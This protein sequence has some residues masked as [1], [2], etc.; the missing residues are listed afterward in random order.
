[1][2]ASGVAAPSRACNP[3]PSV[4]Q[5]HAGAHRRGVAAGAGQREAGEDAVQD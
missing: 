3:E 5:R 1:M 2:G 4:I